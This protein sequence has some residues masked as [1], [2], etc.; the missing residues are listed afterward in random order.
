[1]PFWVV[2]RRWMCVVFHARGPLPGRT[3]KGADH[4]PVYIVL[5]DK[6]STRSWGGAILR[7]GGPHG[8]RRKM[9][10]PESFWHSS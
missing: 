6:K 4:V 3:K 10:Q 8:A 5:P 7:R 2:C 9:A 1:M